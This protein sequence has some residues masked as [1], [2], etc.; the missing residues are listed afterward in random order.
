MGENYSSLP[1]EKLAHLFKEG[2]PYAYTEIYERYKGLLYIHAYRV[3]QDRYSVEDILQDVFLALWNNRDTLSFKTSFSAYLYTAVRNR[4]LDKISHEKVVA[5]YADS[6]RD[7]IEID[8]TTPNEIL[9]EKELSAIIESEVAALPEKMREVFLL[10]RQKEL[11]YK[12]IGERLNISDKTVKQQV[13]N[14][15][16]I[17]KLRINSFI[18]GF[19]F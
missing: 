18:I 4:I 1:D 11:S 15:V 2:D 13:Y 14:A 5:R 10:S 9:R 3:L 7:F 17:L 8:L 6:I 16:K 12:E 19:L